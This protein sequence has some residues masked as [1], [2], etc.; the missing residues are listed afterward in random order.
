MAKTTIRRDMKENTG[1]A[2]DRKVDDRRDGV[3]EAC[4]AVLKPG[5][6][7]LCPETQ[8]DFRLGEPLFQGSAPVLR[9]R[10]A[11]QVQP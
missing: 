3:E 10:K 9:C 2:V 7:G 6:A 5:D 11:G 1:E 8:R 4:G